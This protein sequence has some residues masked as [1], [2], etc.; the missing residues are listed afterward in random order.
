MKRKLSFRKPEPS[1]IQQFKNNS[2]KKGYELI[3]ITRLCKFT[4]G[5]SGWVNDFNEPEQEIYHIQ[6]WY[7]QDNIGA[8]NGKHVYV[9]DEQ[10]YVVYCKDDGWLDTDFILFRKI[11]M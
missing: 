10:K 1:D 5:F 4:L 6:I 2:A 11:K 8:L 9:L 3:D 7:N